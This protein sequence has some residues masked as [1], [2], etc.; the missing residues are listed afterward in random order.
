MKITEK[1]ICDNFKQYAFF[2]NEQIGYL[3]KLC[4]I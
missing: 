4:A 1:M 3:W 2:F